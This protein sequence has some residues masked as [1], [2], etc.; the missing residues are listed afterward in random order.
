MSKPFFIRLHL[1]RS[2]KN[3]HFTLFNIPDMN[4]DDTDA[5][6][7]SFTRLIESSLCLS[8]SITLTND[9]YY[10][11]ENK[12]CCWIVGSCNGLLCLLGYSLNRDMWLH[13]WNPATRKISY[14]LG[15]FG[16]IPSL[17]DLTFGYDNSKDTYK[18]V[19]LLHGGARVFSLDDKVWR[20]IKSFPMGFYHRY[21][22][23]GLH[24]SGIVYYLVIQNY[25]SSFYDCKNII[26]EQFA[27]ISLDLGTETC[28]D[29]LPPR[30]FAEVPHVKP[31][32][33]E[34]L[35]CLC[36]SHVV[37]K[38]HLVIWQMTHYGVEESWSQ[39][40][41]INLQIMTHYGV[42]HYG[43]EK[44][45]DSQWLPLHLSRNY[46]SLVLINN[47]DDLPVV[48]NLRDDS[49]ERIRIINGKRCWRYNKNYYAESLV[50]CR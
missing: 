19:N 47:L 21:I 34:L 48:Y 13:F 3:P 8:K 25:S 6:L 2:S 23:T 50:L 39:L 17:L 12:S 29:L 27:I 11:L 40:L 4:K 44:Y 20:N 24:L 32:L 45:F 30:G 10:R 14:K 28:K 36:F 18:V 41:K 15:R 43:L 33:C 22:S 42:E 7:I 35:D 31:S 9:P 49:V 46:D 37:K 1:Q 38:A 26:V 5:V 16:G